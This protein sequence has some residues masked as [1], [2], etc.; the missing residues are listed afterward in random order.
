[1]FNLQICLSFPD[2]ICQILLE[3]GATSEACNRKNLTPVDIAHN[4][5]IGKLFIR[6]EEAA[7]LTNRRV[8]NFQFRERFYVKLPA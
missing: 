1:M 2:S 3:N 6:T 4:L 7:R 5:K 8:I